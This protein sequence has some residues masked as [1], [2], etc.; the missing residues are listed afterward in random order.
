MNT[1]ESKAADTFLQ[2]NRLE[3]IDGKEYQVAQSSIE[4]LILTSEAISQLPEINMDNTILNESL[5]IAKDCRILGEIA[6]ILILGADGL[7]EKKVIT[8][9]R[10][11]GLIKD[12]YEIILDRKSELAK[13]I[14]KMRPS[15]VN[16][17]MGKLLKRQEISDFFGFTT[18]L[19]EINLLRPTKIETI[20]SGQ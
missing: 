17:L 5:R 4:T 9:K 2:R 11:F 18:S 14:L 13:V 20:P 1:I 10:F 7:E 6:A 15:E 19:Y 3:V 16:L 12:E 8:K